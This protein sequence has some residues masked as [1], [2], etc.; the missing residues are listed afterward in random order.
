MASIKTFDTGYCTHRACVALKG[1]G[2]KRCRF[3]ARAYLIEAGQGKWLWDTGYA[4]H[5]LTHSQAGLFALYR[6]A[7]PVHL[8]NSQDAASQLQ[9]IGLRPHDLDGIIL[10][11]FHGDHIA[12]L[13]DFPG[14]AL[15]CAKDGWNRTRRL[16]GIAA[17]RRGFIPGLMP[18]DVE[19]RLRFVES[20]EQRPLPAELAPFTH[21]Y[22]LPGAEDQVLLVPLPG[23][24]AGHLGAFIHAGDHWILLAS[25]AAWSPASYRKLIGPSALASLITDDAGAYLATLRKLN[26]L[27]QGG[28]VQI[29]LTHEGELE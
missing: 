24:A 3:P 19:Q 18:A 7:T 17:L 5:F 23:H 11:H 1:A 13:H 16:R 26:Q 6:L 8:E 4:S 28:H 20:F 22:A 9:A 21:G 2:W 27:H 12:G 14:T 25:D 15:Y 29:R 10:S